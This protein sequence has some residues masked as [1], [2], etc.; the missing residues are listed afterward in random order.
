AVNAPYSHTLTATGSA[1]ITWLIE[2]GSLPDG[3]I[4]SGAGVLSG[5]PTKVQTA[6]F[7]VKASDGAGQTDTAAF[8]IT[9]DAKATVSISPP[10]TINASNDNEVPIF[11]VSNISGFYV[12]NF[13]Y[14]M[15]DGVK[16]SAGLDTYVYW[17]YQDI[18]SII[19]NLQPK[20]L[21][22]LSLGKHTVT[23]GLRLA[24]YEGMILSTTITILEAPSVK[25]SPSSVIT[26]GKADVT[27]ITIGS[28]L[29]RFNSN[30]FS[31]L[32]MDGNKVLPGTNTYTVHDGSI[33]IRMNPL[34][35]NTLSA[36]KHIVTIGLRG[37]YYK[38]NSVSTTITVAD[39]TAVTP[40][41]STGDHTPIGLLV[42]ALLCA[43][44]GLGI[45][46]SIH[47]RKRHS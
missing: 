4:L 26:M 10:L 20:Y 33:V 23:I 47:M 16:I 28:E 22:A 41:P 25:C 42:I 15:M 37:D 45:A 40:P 14:F 30:N 36:G 21:K 11:L 18:N 9:I 32:L 38:N 6:N 19:F 1:P 12:N 46:V 13:S 5:N 44:C 27:N 29:A 7:T 35:L 8:S 39:G 34:Y 24:P 43:M 2:S 31:Y 3:L 17:H